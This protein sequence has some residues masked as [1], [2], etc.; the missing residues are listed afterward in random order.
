MFDLLPFL[1][2]QLQ[3]PDYLHL[4]LQPFLIQGLFLCA[5]FVLGSL[6][7]R[8]KLA[9]AIGLILTALCAACIF[10]YLQTRTE[11]VTAIQLAQGEHLSSE[12][13]SI[14]VAFNKLAWIYYALSGIALLAAVTI[15]SKKK[16]SPV[17]SI[18]VIIWALYASGLALAYH[19]RDSRL[20][21]PNLTA[22]GEVP[23]SKPET[24]APSP[25]QTPTPSPSTSTTP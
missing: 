18:L 13:Q 1:T 10:P 11:A 8:Q 6:V 4:V 22:P 16:I 9:L 2:E 25:T 23:I 3:L 5:L 17:L 24:I 20:Y 14:A 19:H 15:P 7:C 12:V 21:H